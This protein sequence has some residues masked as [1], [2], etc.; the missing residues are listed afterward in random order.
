MKSVSN[1]NSQH[2]ICVQ[3]HTRQEYTICIRL[4]CKKV[5]LR[6]GACLCKQIRTL[7]EPDVYVD[8]HNSSPPSSF[9]NP[10]S[11]PPS[12]LPVT[13]IN[14]QHHDQ[15]SRLV[16]VA[17][18]VSSQFTHLD[19]IR[20][21]WCRR[22]TVAATVAGDGSFA[23]STSC[24]YEIDEDGGK[25]R[26]VRRR[27]EVVVDGRAWQALVA[28]LSF[29]FSGQQVVEREVVGDGIRFDVVWW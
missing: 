18:S 27:E 12:L 13:K 6:T 11:S 20:I 28:S 23:A 26:W 14:Y 1:N 22:S 15:N 7:L 2:Q 24:S 25:L 3:G 21:W 9:S 10:N 5:K 16:H 29:S 8:W 19:R 4:R 17:D